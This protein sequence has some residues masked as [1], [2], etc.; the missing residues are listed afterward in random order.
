LAG[1]ERGGAVVAATGVD[2]VEDDH[3]F[4]PITQMVTMITTMAMNC[5]S[6]RSRISFCEV[7]GE[8]PRIILTRP[9]TR[10]TAT[11]IIA[12]GTRR[13]ARKLAIASSFY[14]WAR[15][16]AM[17]SPPLGFAP[18]HAFPQC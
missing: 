12:I 9:S 16:E 8:P 10:T 7:C 3:H 2:A 6:T 1:P 13:W 18:R 14:H 15:R 4:G 17:A 5:S 11:A